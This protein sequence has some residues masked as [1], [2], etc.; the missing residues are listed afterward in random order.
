MELLPTFDAMDRQMITLFGNGQ[1]GALIQIGRLSNLAPRSITEIQNTFFVRSPVEQR[2]CPFVRVIMMLEH[3][4]DVVSFEQRHP[5]TPILFA[6]S[7]AALFSL[8]GSMRWIRRHMIDD[9]HVRAIL[10]F[11]QRPRKPIGLRA[12][13]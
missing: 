3:G 12:A 9:E 2:M 6:L 1:I 5:V 11:L 10:T 13:D 8:D 4:I 7:Q